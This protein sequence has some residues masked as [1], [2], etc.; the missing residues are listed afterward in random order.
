M[1][2]LIIILLTEMVLAF[3]SCSVWADSGDAAKESLCEYYFNPMWL[4]PD[5]QSEKDE[6]DSYVAFRGHFKLS[7][8][9]KV[10]IRILGASWFGGW[11][12]GE[13]FAEG[14]ARFHKDYPEYDTIQVNLS[15]GKHLLAVQV[16]Y[17]GLTTRILQDMPPFFACQILKD[18]ESV[19]VCPGI[20]HAL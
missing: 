10:E 12:D 9:G 6:A 20:T 4:A 17:E 16:H 13:F 15:A 5:K 1:R 3:N 19:S 7:E 14:P 8:A 18:G 2:R 11:L